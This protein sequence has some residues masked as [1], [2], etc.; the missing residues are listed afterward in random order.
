M[1]E[2]SSKPNFT[3]LVFFFHVKNEATFTKPGMASCQEMQVRLVLH[4]EA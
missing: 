3:C 1:L 2:K 4:D